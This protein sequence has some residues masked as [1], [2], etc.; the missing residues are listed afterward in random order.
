MRDCCV[1]HA[2]LHTKPTSKNIWVMFIIHDIMY[3]I[4]CNHK[5]DVGVKVKTCPMFKKKKV[6]QIKALGTLYNHLLGTVFN[7]HRED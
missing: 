1:R 5:E 3:V 2:V 4:Q 6:E 7:Q